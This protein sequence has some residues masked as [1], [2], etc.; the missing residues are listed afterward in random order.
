MTLRLSLGLL[1]TLMFITI[2]A[3]L[4][5]AA[6]AH[7]VA[8][9]EEEISSIYVLSTGPLSDVIYQVSQR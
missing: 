2:L 1:A 4:S 9:A 8:P 5:G 6:Q 3:S 7:V